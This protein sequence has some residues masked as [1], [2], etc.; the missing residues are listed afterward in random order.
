MNKNEFLQHRDVSKFI[1]WLADTLPD[2]TFNLKFPPSRYVPGGLEAQ[3]CH[4]NE[5]LQFYR[6]QASWTQRD[7]SVVNSGDWETTKASTAKL[8][9]WLMHALDQKNNEELRQASFA[10]LEWGGVLSSRGFLEQ[11]A[12][13][14]TLLDYIKMVGNIISVEGNRDL[15]DLSEQTIEK[16]NSGLT[17]IYALMDNFGSPIYDSRVGAAIAM[18]YALYRI[19]TEAA[20]TPLLTFP[21]G[22]ARGNQAR[23]P[24]MVINTN[25]APKFYTTAVAPY[26]WAQAQLKLG[27]II[28]SLLQRD[29]NLFKE[30]G[31]L[32]SRC[33]AFEAGL[34]VIGYDLRCFVESIGA[35]NH[36]G[37]IIEAVNGAQ[38][39]ERGWVPTG[40]SF[41][42]VINYFHEFMEQRMD[43][44]HDVKREFREWL[45]A[46][47]KC[48]TQNTAN[49]YLFPLREAEFDLFNRDI[50][51]LKVIAC[52]DREGLEAALG[53]NARFAIG[54]DRQQVCLVDVWLTG[55]AYENRDDQG[56]RLRFLIEDMDAAGTDNAARTLIAVGRN[57]GVH[58]GLLDGVTSQPTEYYREFFADF[59]L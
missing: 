22:I 46:N 12:R 10:V 2:I 24:A 3:E 42:S 26:K 27:W 43:N 14:G 37:A 9:K 5:L 25:A 15:D 7:N 55:Q 6:W 35:N 18:F 45:I 20:A 34:F 36:H 31:S 58:F 11:K 56:G 1:G 48:N 39:Q 50:D 29:Q 38:R 21:V 54:E 44:T 13:N 47:D 17:K 16:F 28:E 4:F 30:E 40:H 51:T 49:A 59:Q 57:V 32:A 23:D 33:H 41:R 53:K 19:E 8:K 52:G